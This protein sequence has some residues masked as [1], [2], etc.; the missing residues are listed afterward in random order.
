MKRLLRF[1]GACVALLCVA[2]LGWWAGRATLTGPSVEDSTAEPVWTQATSATVGR[3]LPYS[4]TVRQPLAP[5]ASNGLEGIVTKV[6]PGEAKQG[7]VLYVVGNTPVRA[8]HAETPMWRDLERGMKG[9]DVKALQAMLKELGWLA[10]E[11]SG[12][13]D[14]TTEAAVK[15]WQKDEGREQTGTVQ[16]GELIALRTLP[17]AITLGTHVALGKQLSG[18]EDAVLAPS[19]EREFLLQLSTE[20][21]RQVPVDVTV[22]ITHGSTTWTGV[23]TSTRNTTDG[24]TEYILSSADGGP[25]CGEQCD[26]L[27]ADAEV[28][29]QS[30]VIVSPMVTGVAVPTAAVNFEPDGSAWVN[31]DSGKTP[32]EVKGSGQGLTVVEGI[33]EGTRVE[34]P[35]A[36]DSSATPSLPAEPPDSPS[37][38]P[39][40][41]G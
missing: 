26:A 21:S 40:E 13:F 9:E 38:S 1:L 6:H 30:R 20:Q 8:V 25:V 37:P 41:D 18:G 3:T 19:G 29:L 4:T 34:L 16:R 33:E 10:G 39:S 14:Q 28:V 22:E 23:V 36:P 17:V 32:V 27:P 12:S 7:S 2:G 15:R 35:T 24:F 11:A 5:V 31:T